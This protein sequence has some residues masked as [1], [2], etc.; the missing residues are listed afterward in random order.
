MGKLLSRLLQW[1]RSL[2]F[3]RK[4]ISYEAT[5]VLEKVADR[6]HRWTIW[7]SC[8]AFVVSIFSF[9][10][11]HEAYKVTAVVSRSAVQVSS[12]KLAGRPE[13]LSFLRYDLVLTNFGQA[14]ARD[15]LIRSRFDISQFDV[16][17][18]SSLYEHPRVGDMPPRF[19]QSVRLQSNERFSSRSDA[20]IKGFKQKL[21]VFGVIEYHDDI[22]GA[23]AKEYWC[24]LYD[25]K[26]AEQVK[27]LELRRCE[28]QY[29]P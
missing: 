1:L 22:T 19:S 21:L 26:D 10:Q 13:D 9:W 28:Y 25:P 20:L 12:A 4:P 7:I 14:T 5:A 16:P 2:T 17:F 23:P 8:A 18:G 27:T 24:F 6:P 11:S 3:P 15:I 29:K